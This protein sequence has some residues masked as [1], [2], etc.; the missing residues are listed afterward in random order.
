[1][2]LDIGQVKAEQEVKVKEKEKAKTVTPKIIIELTEA[3]NRGVTKVSGLKTLDIKVKEI[4]SKISKSL[5]CGTG[6]I[7]DDSFEL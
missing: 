6:S 3:K 5:S 2:S 4:C 7:T 1:M